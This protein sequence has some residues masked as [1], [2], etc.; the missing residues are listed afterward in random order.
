L[1]QIGLTIASRFAPWGKS[2]GVRCGR[3]PESIV[4]VTRLNVILEGGGAF[5]FCEQLGQQWSRGALNLKRACG[6]H[7]IALLG[8]AGAFAAEY[9]SRNVSSLNEFLRLKI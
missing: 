2:F 8:S 6:S 4:E 7:A 3:S 1:V 5:L 9:F